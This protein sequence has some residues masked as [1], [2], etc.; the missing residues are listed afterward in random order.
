VVENHHRLVG[1]VGIAAAA[2]LKELLGFQERVGIALQAAGIPRKIDE[3]ALAD[4]AGISA[5]GFV[6]HAGLTSGF[7][8]F[9][10]GA[11]G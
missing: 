8:E 1:E 4:V 3:Q 9:P 10:A 11:F 2:G 6:R 5:G 7:E